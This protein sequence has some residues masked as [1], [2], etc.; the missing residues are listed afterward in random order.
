MLVCYLP[1]KTAMNKTI[2]VLTLTKGGAQVVLE[3]IASKQK[4]VAYLH[5][6]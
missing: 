6:V 3:D 2:R 1:L 5:V 4:L